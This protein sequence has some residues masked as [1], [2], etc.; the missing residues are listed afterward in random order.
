MELSEDEGEV[1]LRDEQSFGIEFYLLVLSEDE[2]QFVIRIGYI[3]KLNLLVFSEDEGEFVLRYNLQKEEGF[4]YKRMKVI[5][6]EFEG[7]DD[8]LDRIVIKIDNVVELVFDEN[9]V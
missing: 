3:E 6:D 2:G 8:E 1:V 9:I 4:L 7:N 5:E